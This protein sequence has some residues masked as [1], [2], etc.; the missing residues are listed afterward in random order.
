MHINFLYKKYDLTF[1][2]TLIGKQHLGIL[3]IT[4]T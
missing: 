1:A 2:E 4:Q 3:G